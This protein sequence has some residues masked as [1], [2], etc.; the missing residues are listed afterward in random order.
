VI[1]RPEKYEMPPTNTIE[2][3]LRNIRIVHGVI[4][5]AMVLIIYNGEVLIP[6][7]LRDLGRILPIAYGIV[8]LHVIGLAL[9]FRTTKIRPALEI[10]QLKPDDPKALQQWRAGGILTAVLM[11]T[12]V[13]FGFSLLFIGAAPK[14]SLPFYIA[15]IALMLLWWPQRP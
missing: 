1:S 2:G 11:D 6:H 9:Y 13:L 4:L 14:I 10:L 3:S 7:K 5:F 8:S 15:G 12:V